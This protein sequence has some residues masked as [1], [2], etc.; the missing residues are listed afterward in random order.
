M[1]EGSH[2]DLGG[3]YDVAGLQPHG[4]RHVQLRGEGDE[5]RERPARQHNAPA[6][7]LQLVE[8]DRRIQAP[9]IQ[10]DCLDQRGGGVAFSHPAAAGS[11]RFCTPHLR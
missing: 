1:A 5:R 7:A 4:E 9:E 6:Q 3:I 8:T 2:P 10:R 11:R